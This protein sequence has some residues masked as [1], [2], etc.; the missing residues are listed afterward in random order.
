MARRLIWIL[1]GSVVAVVV[2]IVIVA[3]LHGSRSINCD[4]LLVRATVLDLVKKNSPLPNNTD[5]ELDAIHKTGG[6]TAAGKVSCEAKVFGEFN[7]APYS[8]TQLTYSVTRQADGQIT[9][10]VKGISGLKFP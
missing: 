2:A 6:D 3:F 7:N 10:S 8:S 9:V 1:G 5:Y 4:D